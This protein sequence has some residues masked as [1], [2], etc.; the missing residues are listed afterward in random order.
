MSLPNVA[1][2]MLQPRPRLHLPQ[3]HTASA[4]WSPSSSSTFPCTLA[5]DKGV[6]VPRSQSSRAS[7]YASMAWAPTVTPAAPG[8]QHVSLWRRRSRIA[9]LGHH[10]HRRHGRPGS[11]RGFSSRGRA[12][13]G[14]GRARAASL[15]KHGGLHCTRSCGR[16]GPRGGELRRV[17]RRSS[18]PVPLHRP[19]RTS[20]RAA[21]H[22]RRP[23]PQHP[24]PPPR[25]RAAAPHFQSAPAGLQRAGRTA[26]AHAPL[27]VLS[28]PPPRAGLGR[29]LGSPTYPSPASVVFSLPAAFGGLRDSKPAC[30][31][32][33]PD[34]KN[35][36]APSPPRG[37]LGVSANPRLPLK[38]GKFAG[39]TRAGRAGLSSP[40]SQRRNSARPAPVLAASRALSLPPCHPQ[41]CDAVSG[42]HGSDSSVEL[43]A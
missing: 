32:A 19:G 6:P 7:P 1:R 30:L 27:G 36:Q 21:A 41:S 22:T 15:H 3:F 29:P 18:R 43:T 2:P 16:Y 23:S 31:H 37:A 9:S 28:P 12:R 4:T 38:A 13:V 11:R 8:G 25:Q 26:T 42:L 34:F 40:S 33:L 39:R 24:L 14:G 5:E 20:S 35:K 10:R 17:H